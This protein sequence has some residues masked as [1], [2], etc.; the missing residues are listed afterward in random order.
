M[1]CEEVV[2][3][4][5][6][7]LDGDLSDA[8]KLALT[9][10]LEQCPDCAAMFR[11][12]QQLHSG[13]VSLPKVEPPFSLVDALLPRLDELDRLRE[14]GRGLEENVEHGAEQFIALAAKEWGTQE[15]A[16]SVTEASASKVLKTS[17]GERL[18][19]VEGGKSS[20]GPGA[21]A[22]LEPVKR[23]GWMRGGAAWGGAL[24][25]AALFGVIVLTSSGGLGLDEK[26]V[27]EMSPQFS[28]SGSSGEAGSTAA[29]DKQAGSGAGEA[30]GTEAASAAKQ[31]EL[32]AAK[33]SAAESEAQAAPGAG[34]A[35]A[36][37]PAPIQAG[38]GAEQPAPE[39]KQ[40]QAKL[41]AASASEPASQP[42]P[43]E[44]V[45]APSATPQ[46]ASQPDTSGD[47]SKKLAEPAPM[48]ES[49][50]SNADQSAAASTPAA[51]GA[52]ES[53]PAADSRGL[54]SKD[55]SYKAQSFV[56]EAAGMEL[57][58]KDGTLLAVV[59]DQRIVV[60]KIGSGEVLYTSPR[61][62]KA[63]D[64]LT[65]LSWDSETQLTYQVVSGE[66]KQLISMDLVKKTETV[67]PG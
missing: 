39:A 26:E 7:E 16:G 58:S 55:Y 23:K 40:P 46:P 30:V 35:S 66:V 65:L 32:A 64:K 22:Q 1:I 4:M 14:Q 27:A 44:T 31:D 8:E 9:A 17:G 52:E 12:M 10:H 28:S 59:Q 33:Q 42:A 5:Q 43:R 2:E 62:W 15:A 19:A 67:K 57:S 38:S 3:L 56:Y 53:A 36:N 47:A 11:R 24:A 29:Q 61:Q 50:T 41:P 49:Q 6:R 51:P 48:P 18:A 45:T 20:R 34:A 21:A 13:L 60:K 37:E 54:A 25:A 63:T